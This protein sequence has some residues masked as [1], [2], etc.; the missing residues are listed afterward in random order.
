MS[1]VTGVM[2][3]FLILSF[4]LWVTAEFCYGGEQ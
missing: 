2:Y 4:F 3:A 1:F